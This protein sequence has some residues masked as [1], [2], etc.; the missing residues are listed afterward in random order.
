MLASLSVFLTITYAFTFHRS[1]FIL[2]ISTVCPLLIANSFDQTIPKPVPMFGNWH[3]VCMHEYLLLFFTL[4][5]IKT[6]L[7]PHR[8][9][10]LSCQRV[11]QHVNF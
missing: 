1:I 5:V 7:L 8:S 10:N 11:L 9:L 2:A 4:W 3:L 6:Q